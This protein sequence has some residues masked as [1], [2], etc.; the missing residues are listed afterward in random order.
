MPPTLTAPMPPRL[1]SFDCIALSETAAP[2]T[3]GILARTR[4][5]ALVTAQELFPAL[6][7]SVVQISP[8]W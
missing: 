7:I 2:R 4:T 6:T 8:E 5:D 3:I 1:L